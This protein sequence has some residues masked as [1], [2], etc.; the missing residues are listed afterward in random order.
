MYQGTMGR[1]SCYSECCQVRKVASLLAEPLNGERAVSR[2]CKQGG[3]NGMRKVTLASAQLKVE[4]SKTDN[5]K[6]CLDFMGEAASRGADVLV[7]PELF[8]Q[9]Y[10]DFAFGLGAR[11]SA[12]QKRYYFAEAEPIPGPSTDRVA[13]AA[14]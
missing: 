13:E 2:W 10:A 11:E 4:H 3:V 9:G 7:F 12:D 14:R 6:K 5:L 8:L 1:R